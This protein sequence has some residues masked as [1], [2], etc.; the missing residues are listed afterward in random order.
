[1]SLWL[2]LKFTLEWKKWSTRFQV[3]LLT[4]HW[5]WSFLVSS[6]CRFLLCLKED[7]NTGSSTRPWDDYEGVPWFAFSVMSWGCPYGIFCPN[8]GSPT[9]LNNNLFQALV[10]EHSWIQ[11]SNAKFVEYFHSYYSHLHH[12]ISPNCWLWALGMLAIIVRVYI[13]LLSVRD[14]K[15][16][17]PVLQQASYK[18]F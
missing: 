18:S 16:W 9:F 6:L 8:K 3:M 15:R 11:A 1:M 17:I 2:F 13:A 10:L 14:D 12:W 5:L 4:L 7:N